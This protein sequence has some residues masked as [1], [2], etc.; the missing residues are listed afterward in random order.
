MRKQQLSQPAA[1][2]AVVLA[3][4]GPAYWRRISELLPG[5]AGSEIPSPEFPPEI[6][7]WEHEPSRRQ[8]LTLMGASLALAGIGGCTSAPQESIVPY[9]RQPENV[10]PGQTQ[11]Y[12]TAARTGDNVLG[13]VVK[14]EAGRPIKI[15]GNPDH[16]ASLGATNAFCQAE[17]LTLYDPDR[18]QTVLRNQE[19]ETWDG[20]L[21]SLKTQLEKSH[22]N[23]GVGLRVLSEVIRS[24]TLRAQRRALLTAFP[25]AQWH[26]WEPLHN[27]H[28]RAGMQLAFDEEA[29]VRYRLDRADVILSLD[30][31]FLTT[32]EDHV[33]HAR[34]YRTRRTLQLSR[35][36]AIEMNRLYVVESTPSL[37]GAAA[38]HRLTLEP[39]AIEAL[40]REIAARLGLEIDR[41]GQEHL[42]DISAEWIEAVV[43][44]LREYRLKSEG[45][46]ALVIPGPSQPP[47]V[48]A[49]AHFINVRM[50]S[51]GKTVEYL[52]TNRT[53]SNEEAAR[54]QN[55]T[56]SLQELVERMRQGKVTTLAI[57]G[58]NPV[59][60]APTDINF[61]AALANVGFSVHLSLYAD[62]TSHQ[63]QWHIPES[64]FLEAWS[65]LQTYDGITSIV[66]PLITPLYN[67]KTAHEIVAA[68]LDNGT[69]SAKDLV[70]N[71]WKQ[72]G[73]DAGFDQRWQEALQKGVISDEQFPPSR[74]SLVGDLAQK[75]QAVQRQVEAEGE[76]TV[77]FRAD[78]TIYDGR[79]ANNG[80]LQELPKP[81]TKLTWDNAA[82]ISPAAAEEMGLASGDVVRLTLGDRS[83]EL[84]VVVLPGQLKTTLTLHL[85]YGRKHAGRVGNG[86]GFNTYILRT[87]DAPWFAFGARIEKMGGLHPLAITVGH[88]D[89]EG[90][91]LIRAGTLAELSHE[92]TPEFMASAGRPTD[93]QSL[94]P[95]YPREGYQWGMSIDL[96]ACTGCNA[97]VVAC[98]AENNIPIVGRDEVARGRE[99][100]WIRID[101]Y[102]RG[103]QENP[104]AFHQPVPCMHCENAPCE[105]VCP[106]A[107]TVHSTEGLNQMVYNRCVGTRY[108]SNNCPY[109]VR[110]FNFL[111]YSDFETP[112]LKLMRNPQVT[113]RSRGVMEKCTYCIQR[114][115]AARI[116][117]EKEERT[118]TDREVQTA[119][120]QVCPSQ[121]ILFGNLNDPQSGVSQAKHNPLDYALLAELNARPRTSYL[122]AVRNPNPALA[123]LAKQ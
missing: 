46:S 19:I 91:E 86:A 55:Q 17:L 116:N 22:A 71:H 112:V 79:Y 6:E 30:A 5:Q 50:G 12:A 64:H 108:C 51:V 66:Q 70:Q 88:H 26:E 31:D 34:E 29:I 61:S 110:R 4:A 72:A 40:A 10:T 11:E 48:H 32:G 56:D 1:E 57:L 15:E 8:F 9:I 104:E 52:S 120:Q 77:V 35:T 53:N 7:L 18:S 84:P 90:R 76:F 111:E 44:D 99:M 60:N 74:L 118:I 113:V 43:K 100:H 23:N 80:W 114:I 101:S 78:P 89:L 33:R 93:S 107:A 69:A 58:G 96:T 122:A 82:L 123:L 85:G 109:K 36:Q 65:D 38:D 81:F 42:A 45:G 41:P 54:F 106:V 28:A 24:P 27:D 98:Q 59:Y 13:L 37:T 119:C 25:Q 21:T 47:E 49:L 39:R 92:A 67:S 20:F 115:S 68:L 121:A 62:E 95:P 97:C 83:L 14:S 117:A 3:S 16:P 73:E 63:C 94:F 102:Y 87:S 75:L 2:E 103:E 105:L